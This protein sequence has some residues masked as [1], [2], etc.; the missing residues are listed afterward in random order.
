MHENIFNFVTLVP[1]LRNFDI[2]HCYPPGKTAELCVTMLG[3]KVP[4]WNIFLEQTFCIQKSTLGRLFNKRHSHFVINMYLFH[5]MIRV[6]CRQYICNRDQH[7]RSKLIKVNCIFLINLFC[8]R[9]K[10]IKIL[11]KNREIKPIII[12]NIYI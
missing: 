7:K 8:N 9:I 12:S 1:E 10:F 4:K 2:S 5:E 11:N 3:K 6:I